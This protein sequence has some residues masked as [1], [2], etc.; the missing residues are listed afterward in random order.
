MHITSAF[1]ILNQLGVG[2]REG[3][4]I[5][6]ANAKW[7]DYLGDTVL[8]EAV[9]SYIYLRVRL[10][11]DSASLTGAVI[12]SINQTIKELEWRLNVMVDTR[13]ED[14]QPIDYNKLANLPTI[15]GEP[16]TGNYNERDPTVNTVSAS[17]VDSAWQKTITD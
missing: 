5:Y 15:N 13:V 10:L 14:C 8:L 4:R 6:D 11:F 2:P 3:F 1:M 9:K 16:L 17:E 12:E 7:T